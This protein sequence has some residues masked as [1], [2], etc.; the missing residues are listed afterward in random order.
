MTALIWS[1][2]R[3]RFGRALALAAGIL[4]AAT[5]F[6]LL[7]S[8]VTTSRAETVG[9]VNANARSAYDILVRP[10]GTTTALE[11]QKGLVEADF[12][13]GIF[14]GITLDQYEKI[15]NLPQLDVAAP[16]ANI[17]Y[18]PLK[19]TIKVDV[20]AFLDGTAPAQLLRL[21]P[22]LSAGLS[23]YPVADQYVYLT[24]TDPIKVVGNP[25]GRYYDLQ[26]ENA[27][28][29]KYWV[30]WYYNYDATGVTGKDGGPLTSLEDL[31]REGHPKTPFTSATRSR[32]TCQAGRNHAY[33]QIPTVFPVLLS[34]IDPVQEDRLVG[35]RGAVTSGRMLNA[36][37]KPYW[38][39]D[40]VAQDLVSGQ[41]NLHV[42]VLLSD[43][44]MSSGRL[45]A[46]VE[47]LD[48]GDPR[49]L[50]ARLGGPGARAFV[51]G[52]HGTPVGQASADLADAYDNTDLAQAVWSTGTYMTVGPVRYRSSA[53]GFIAVPRPPADPHMWWSEVDEDWLPAPEENT[54]TQFR[55]VTGWTSTRCMLENSCGGT[56]DDSRTETPIL[57]FVGRFDRTKVRAFSA[58]SSVPMETYESPQVTGADAATRAALGGRPLQP[59][60][61]L[62][63]YLSQPP[64]MLTTL[65]SAAAMTMSRHDPSV[66]DKAPVSAVRIRVVGV[67]GVDPVSRARVNAAVAAI[68]RACPTLDIDVT[69]GSSPA[70][71]TVILPGN[72]KVSEGWTGK[73]VALRILRGVDTK[74]AVLFVLVLVVCGIFLGQSALAS[75]RSRRTEIGIFRCL[76]WRTRDIFIAI[77]G[78]LLAVG[79]IAGA[80]GSLLAYALGVLLHL[81]TRPPH[82]ALVLPVA[83]LLALAAGT[84]PAWRAARVEPLD[85]VRP[86]VVPSG[87]S[88]P[89]R[90]LAGMALRNLTRVP[91]RTALGA[92]GLA[93]GVAAFTILLAVTLAFRGEVTGSLLGNAVVAQARVADY[94]SVALSLLLGAAGAVDVLVLSQRE[95]A[96]DLAVLRATGW[97]YRDLARLPLYE[98]IGLALL[99]S[100]TGSVLG[101]GVIAALG[102]DLLG[103]HILMLVTAGLIGTLAALLL[104]TVT[105]IIPIRAL[106]RIAPASLLA[107]G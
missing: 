32:L 49:R 9:T 64:T 31:E 21:R 35:L 84:L 101:V 74:S 11:R 70:P 26:R 44:V 90:S 30:C 1:Q 38:G 42:P 103:G 25:G 29:G 6:T 19:S 73:G 33:A 75:V 96:G 51:D 71:Q 63:G 52:L 93:L 78:E 24:R 82:A 69:V 94:L 17:G 28:G 56:S 20:S 66:Q 41:Q 81:H 47:R 65:S 95:R 37:D 13:S 2:L 80:L 99:G 67:S 62:G 102:S 92:A 40:T 72:A 43:H 106:N 58:L 91:G 61:N 14:G 105:L 36:S 77:L 5:S 34:A 27:P 53:G 22:A 97:T 45:T 87:R 98:G 85:A 46:T 88:R 54:G 100:L 50:P 89:V 23:R 8:V 83:V 60:R 18:I 107:A 48:S 68:H 59:D 57:R 79:L 16:I 4:V 55:D 104:I 10:P 15:K 86:P 7:T 12:L 39:P 76:G 3:R